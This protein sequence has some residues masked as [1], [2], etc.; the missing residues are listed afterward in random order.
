LQPRLESNGPDTY[1]AEKTNKNVNK[2]E[3]FRKR[4]GVYRP[5]KK[6]NI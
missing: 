3:E 6:C 1:F 2:K 5:M 4:N